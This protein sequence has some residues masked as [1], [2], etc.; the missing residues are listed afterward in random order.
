VEVLRRDGLKRQHLVHAR[1]VH[2]DIELAVGL[3]SG[4]NDGLCVGG[5]GDVTLDGDG[6]AAR[7][8]DGGDDLVGTGFVRC[9]VDDDGGASGPE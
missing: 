2:E 6:L 1:V 9:V 7:G 4:V 8:G 5:F 3:D